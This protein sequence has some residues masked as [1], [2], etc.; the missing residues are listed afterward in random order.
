[1]VV[2][3]VGG[4]VGCDVS[5][6]PR[7]DARPFLCGGLRLGGPYYCRQK[8]GEALSPPLP[9]YKNAILRTTAHVYLCCAIKAQSPPDSADRK[10]HC[11]PRTFSVLTSITPVLRT[12]PERI[13]TPRRCTFRFQ[14]SVHTPLHNSTHSHSKTQHA[15]HTHPLNNHK[16]SLAVPLA[17]R[18]AFRHGNRKA[19][20]VRNSTL[21]LF[22]A[23][24][25]HDMPLVGN[26]GEAGAWRDFLRFP[27]RETDAK[28]GESGIQTGEGGPNYVHF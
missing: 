19:G 8:K 5:Q 10:R 26:L 14:Q 28:N 27:Y 16:T 20:G 7:M 21:L 11:C 15:N 18:Q 1:M 6:G 17:G 24:K 9:P 3:L 13:I 22:E 12:Y 25:K 4:E 2:S 23:R